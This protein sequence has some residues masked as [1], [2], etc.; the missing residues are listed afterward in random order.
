M[1]AFQRTLEKGACFFF[2]NFETFKTFNF[3][4]FFNFFWEGKFFCHYFLLFKNSNLRRLTFPNS[5]TQLIKSHISFY[6]FSIPIWF[7]FIF[8]VGIIYSLV[9]FPAV[10]LYWLD[11][12]FLLLFC[13][14]FSRINFYCIIEQ[15]VFSVENIRDKIWLT[16]RFMKMW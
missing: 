15:N 8:N 13:F 7:I 12:I 2:I 1:L 9:I 11:N 6:L 5:L 3:F 16:R 14:L 10:F 4:L